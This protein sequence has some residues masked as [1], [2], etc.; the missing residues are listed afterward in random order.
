MLNRT[1]INN[2]IP[3]NKTEDGNQVVS[4][5]DLHDFLAVKADFPTWLK[6]MLK[7]G[8]T[9]DVD[10][11]VIPKIVEDDTGFGGH[12]KLK[13]YAMTLDMAKEI[14]MIQRTEK[15][16][17]ARQ[18][19]IEVEKQYRRPKPM[20][21]TEQL[22]LATQSIGEIDERVTKLE[23]TFPISNA[24]QQELNQLEHA[25][26][27]KHLG[28]MDSNAYLKLKGKVFSQGWRAFN[29]HFHIPRYC[30][31]PKL[32]FENGKKYLQMWAPDTDLRIEI[33]EANGQTNM[34]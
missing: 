9:K 22:L 25:V 6:R 18:Y 5:R 34:F 8:F 29:R 16:K 20:T 12:R 13:D 21:A 17:Q 30:E 27:I 31:L 10:F 32:E 24:Q 14:A 19:F 26:A 28:G 2:L 11:I 1:N 3:V 7:Y 4:G 33:Q 23:D 15:G